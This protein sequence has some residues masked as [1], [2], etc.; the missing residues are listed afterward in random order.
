MAAADGRRGGLGWFVIGLLL[1]VAGT[2]ATQRFVQTAGQD[3]QPAASLVIAPAAPPAPEGPTPAPKPP[4]HHHHEAPSSAPASAAAGE[5]AT[6]EFDEDAA[7]AGMTSR[8]R[9][10]TQAVN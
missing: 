4:V 5:R 1:G 7:A 3:A 2:L 8:T 6:S 10:D 9:Q